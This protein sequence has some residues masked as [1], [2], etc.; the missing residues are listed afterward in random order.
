MQEK[1]LQCERQIPLSY[2][3]RTLGHAFFERAESLP[4]FKWLAHLSVGRPPGLTSRKPWPVAE[5]GTD[6]Y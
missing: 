1:D 4:P 2:V 5:A 6:S 3:T